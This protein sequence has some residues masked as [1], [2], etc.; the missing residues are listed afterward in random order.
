MSTS[1]GQLE[2]GCRRVKASSKFAK[3]N[4]VAG[5]E[6]QPPSG[7]EPVLSRCTAALAKQDLPAW[8]TRAAQD[9]TP[10]MPLRGRAPKNKGEQQLSPLQAVCGPCQSCPCTRLRVL[11]S[12]GGS[13]GPAEPGACATFAVGN[14]TLGAGSLHALLLQFLLIPFTL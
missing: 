10:R 4:G 1:E 12:T 11:A 5:V 2:R 8:E 6:G 13:R 14:D 9:S 3:A 7:A